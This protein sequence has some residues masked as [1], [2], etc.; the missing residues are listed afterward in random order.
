MRLRRHFLFSFAAITAIAGCSGVRVISVSHPNEPEGIPYY[1]PR[2][3]VQVFEPFI[4]GASN[5]FVSGVLSSDKSYLLIDNVEDQGEL[6]DLFKS[7]LSKDAASRIPVAV[8]RDPSGA[9]GGAPQGAAEPAAGEADKGEKKEEAPGKPTPSAPPDSG[10]YGLS[11]T[12][13]PTPFTP[14]LGRRFFD[15]VWLPDFDEKHVVQ[16]TPGLGKA[17]IGIVLTQGW[18][19]HGLNATIDNSALA[20]PL[21]DFFTSLGKLAASRITPASKLG[22]AP[23]GAIDTRDMTAGQRVT[24]KV[25]KA[26]V[27]APGLYPVLKPAELATAHAARGAHPGKIH[28]PAPPFTNLAFNTYEA[29]LVEAA[30]PSGDSIPGLQQAAPPPAAPSQGAGAQAAP[31]PAEPDSADV[32]ALEKNLNALLASRKSPTSEYWKLSGLTLDGGKLKGTATLVGGTHKPPQLNTIEQLKLFISKQTGSRF[33]PKDIE[34][35]EAGD[36][37]NPTS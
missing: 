35:V 21:L 2:P 32:A 24:V 18:G 20:R 31:Y 6:G 15:I 33:K 30:R 8:V 3:Y 14:I 16:G 25:T 29:V 34:L 17:E 37:Q 22:G 11:V 9:F 5:Y 13:T 4:I 1:L 23:Q 12:T 10:R 26:T 19:L 27:A 36:G 7:D 28:L